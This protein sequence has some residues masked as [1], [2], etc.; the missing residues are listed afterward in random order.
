M[1]FGLGALILGHEV[2][3]HEGGE[4]PYIL[5]AALSLCGVASFLKL[6]EVLKNAGIRISVSKPDTDSTGE[7]PDGTARPGPGPSPEQST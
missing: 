5:L 2:I 4:R 1:A 3:I 7:A 6:D